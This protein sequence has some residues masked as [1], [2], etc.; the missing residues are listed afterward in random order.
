MAEGMLPVELWD[1]VTVDE[2]L[3]FR[4]YGLELISILLGMLNNFLCHFAM[5]NF[6]DLLPPSNYN[7]ANV[8]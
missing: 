1:V 8:A 6:I 2:Y 5:Y 4:L 7:R 3:Q